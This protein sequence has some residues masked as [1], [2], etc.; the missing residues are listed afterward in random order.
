MNDLE[1]ALLTCVSLAAAI[2]LAASIWGASQVSP[3]V[4]EQVMQQLVAEGLMEA[5]EEWGDLSDPVQC[6]VASAVEE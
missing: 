4:R 5:D 1:F 2:G 6:A 3:R